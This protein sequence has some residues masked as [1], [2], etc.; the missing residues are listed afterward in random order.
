MA[1]LVDIDSYSAEESL[2]FERQVKEK[3]EKRVT[4]FEEFEGKKRK[5]WWNEESNFVSASIRNG[6]YIIHIKEKIWNWILFCS[7]ES[8]GADRN[9][10]I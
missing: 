2:R 1:E 4:F 9:W 3:E 7:S 8:S 5:K 10:R 6:K